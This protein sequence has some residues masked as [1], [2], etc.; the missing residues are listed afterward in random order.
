MSDQKNGHK[1]FKDPEDQ[2]FG[3]LS[4]GVLLEGIVYAVFSGDLLEGF[5]VF[6]CDLN[7]G[8]SGILTDELLHGLLAMG[9]CGGL[10]WLFFISANSLMSAAFRTRP[11]IRVVLTAKATVLFSTS[12]CMKNTSFHR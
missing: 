8:D 7:V 1:R 9:I 4:G 10:S 3:F 12:S 5:D 6:V 2:I 11:V